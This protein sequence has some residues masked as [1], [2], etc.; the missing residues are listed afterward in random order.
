MMGLFSKR[1]VNHKS[2]YD[3]MRENWRQSSESELELINQ[4]IKLLQEL[5]KQ[6]RD[7]VFYKRLIENKN[8]RI[9]AYEKLLDEAIEHIN[10][11]KSDK[12]K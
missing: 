4:N 11:L 6:D 7:I 2:M 5:R 12:D 9:A 3:E 1:Q 8:E 10:S